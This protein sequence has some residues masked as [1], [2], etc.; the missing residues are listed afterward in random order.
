MLVVASIRISII[1]L[2][3]YVW[4]KDELVSI[5]WLRLAFSGHVIL[6]YCIVLMA[7]KESVVCRELAG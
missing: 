2:F 3:I 5:V 1:Y 6:F 4:R 7:A